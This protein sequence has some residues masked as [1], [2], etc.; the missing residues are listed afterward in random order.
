MFN[1]VLPSIC[2]GISCSPIAFCSSFDTAKPGRHIV[3]HDHTLIHR[4]C[5]CTHGN[6]SWL[7]YVCVINRCH[8]C[9]SSVHGR[10]FCMTAW[11]FALNISQDVIS[12]EK[13]W[14]RPIPGWGRAGFCR[15]HGHVIKFWCLQQAVFSFVF[16]NELIL[17]I[18]KRSD[19]LCGWHHF[20]K[21]SLVTSYRRC[22]WVLTI[23]RDRIKEICSEK[24]PNYTPKF[25]IDIA[26]ENWWLEGTTFLWGW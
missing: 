21:L 2:Q 19:L 11:S 18:F 5:H 15:W 7:T 3:T 26:P 24:S 25:S 4:G 17:F 20:R 16:I 22:A 12:T 1:K 23:I 13:H 8:R 14:H 10:Q 9:P 6:K